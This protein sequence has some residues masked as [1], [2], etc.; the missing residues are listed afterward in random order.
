V[1]KE[2]FL[3]SMGKESVLLRASEMRVVSSILDT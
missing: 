3:L 2:S 1:R